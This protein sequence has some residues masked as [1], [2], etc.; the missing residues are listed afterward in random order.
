MFANGS[1]I[2]GYAHIEEIHGFDFNSYDNEKVNNIINQALNAADF[3]L[4]I[5]EEK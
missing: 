1:G 5:G 2:V 3:T 4:K